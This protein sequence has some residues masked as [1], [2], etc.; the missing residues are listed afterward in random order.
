MALAQQQLTALN[1]LIRAI[2]PSNRFYQP[3][4]AAAG[5]LDG[6]AALDDFRARM[7]FTTKAEPR[8]LRSPV[9]PHCS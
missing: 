6:F 2:A 9:K 1:R 8:P 3:K 4:L 7:P 5:G